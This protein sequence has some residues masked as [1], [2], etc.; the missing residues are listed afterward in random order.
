MPKSKAPKVFKVKKSTIN[1]NPDNLVVR[2]KNLDKKQ[3]KE[4]KRDLD[5][6]C[7]AYFCE[8]VARDSNNCVQ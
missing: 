1:E 2:F 3:V 7:Q 6:F 8:N 5:E 4:F